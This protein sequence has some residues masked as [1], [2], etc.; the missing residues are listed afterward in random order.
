M[1]SKIIT[2]KQERLQF[3]MKTWGKI[4]AEKE[5]ICKVNDIDE[6]AVTEIF[7]PDTDFLSIEN[8]QGFVM[9]GVQKVAGGIRRIPV[10][11]L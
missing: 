9:E 5:R 8:I 11:I 2:N 10:I 1:A 3:I 6:E 4:K 7:V